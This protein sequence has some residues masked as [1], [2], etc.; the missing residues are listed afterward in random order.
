MKRLG[1]ITAAA[2]VLF[3]GAAQ[4]APNDHAAQN[5][6]FHLQSQRGALGVGVDTDFGVRNVV[7]D[8]YGQTHVR[9]MQFVRGVKVFGGEAIVHMKGDQ[10]LGVTNDLRRGAGGDPN[11][12]LAAPDAVGIAHSALAPMG[13]YNVEPSAE[14][15]YFRQ[16]NGAYAL[17]YHVHAELENNF[18]TRHEDFM[19]DARSGRILDRWNSLETAGTTNTGSSQ[20]SGSVTLDV[21]SISG[22]YELRDTTRSNNYTTNLNHATSGNGAVY[23]DADGTWGDGANYVEGSSTTAANGETAAVDAHFGMTKTWDYYAQVHGRNGIDGAGSTTYS[24]VH[25]SNSYDNAFWSDSCFCMTY[26]DGSSFKTLTAIDVAGHEMTHG[27]TART[28]GLT[29]RR[30]S[31]GLNEAMSDIMGTNVEFWGTNHGNWQIGEQLATNPLRYMYKP[32]LDGASADCWSKRVATLD[33]HYSSGVGNHLYYLLSQ[34]SNASPASPTCNGST[35]TGVGRTTAEKIMYLALTSYMTS[36]TDYKGARAAT[37]SA[38]A[39]LYGTGSAQYNA[40]AAAWSAVG[41]N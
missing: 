14:L 5:A 15:V 13:H 41:V 35:V 32:S 8:N 1:T 39:Q 20:Y 23:T 33:V 12:R 40:V 7:A 2:L 29:Y 24:R 34:G 38:A 11:P 21:N 9:A 6:I 37:L 3:G 26:G 4:A 28:A 22:G 19:V 31:G 16:D 30:E 25:Y 17:A 27:V 36:S 10:V 18:E